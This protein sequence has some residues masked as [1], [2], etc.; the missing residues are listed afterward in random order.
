MKKQSRLIKPV[1]FLIV[2]V[3]TFFIC[4]L[5]IRIIFPN[6]ILP[7]DE[8]NSLYQ[9]DERLGWF[10]KKNEEVKFEGTNA[11]N[12]THNEF[13]FRDKQHGPK[14]KDRIVFIGD[15]FTWG[16]DVEEGERF[17]NLLQEQI[18]DWD[19]LNLGVSGYGTDQSFILLKDCF[20]QYQPDIVF[21]TFCNM[22]DRIENSSRVIYGGYYKPHFLVQ[23]NK[24][25]LEGLPVKKSYRYL[26]SKY[27]VLSKSR[28]I[29]ML[30]RAFHEISKPD[31]LS[32]DPTE[33]IFVA[34]K[35]YV[36][37]KGSQFIIGFV[38]GDQ[39]TEEVQWCQQH[40]IQH[41][42][43]SNDFKYPS[44]GKH[45]TPEGHKFVSDKILTYLRMNEPQIFS[46]GQTQE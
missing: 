34:L 32:T 13:G 37:S 16:Y 38:D 18:N 25:Q 31:K 26:F 1:A 5:A 14:S 6:R 40:G 9:F 45:W 17:T 21:L 19:L 46:N 20:D 4:E 28:L 23:E 41:I 12:V 2:L 36:E 29:Y 24:I 39:S 30:F 22:N 43:L 27:P 3:F 11:I 33:A 7:L 42:L 35:N 15:S 8:R 44:H 10:P